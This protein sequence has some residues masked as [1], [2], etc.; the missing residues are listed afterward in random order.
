MNRGKEHTVMFCAHGQYHCALA[1]QTSWHVSV[2]FCARTW[3]RWT[4]ICLLH[5]LPCRCNSCWHSQQHNICPSQHWVVMPEVRP[6]CGAPGSYAF[7]TQECYVDLKAWWIWW[8]DTLH[9]GKQIHH[10]PNYLLAV[11][12]HKV[13]LQRTSSGWNQG[14]YHPFTVSSTF[15][16]TLL[17]LSA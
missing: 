10:S 6:G 3:M 5:L 12:G 17:Q 8:P 15:L 11:G 1:S 16:A 7:W 4:D 14:C 13:G 2:E 9:R